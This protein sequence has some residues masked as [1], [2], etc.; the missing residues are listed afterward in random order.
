M[1]DLIQALEEFIEARDEY[2]K[3]RRE[4]EYDAGYYC[5]REQSEME[6]KAEEFKKQFRVAVIEA[7]SD[8]WQEQKNMEALDE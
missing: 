3:C 8:Y 4:C 5:S 1:D 7:M 2:N 6:D